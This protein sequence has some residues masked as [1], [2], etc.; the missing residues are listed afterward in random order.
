MKKIFMT[1]LIAAAL[2]ACNNKAKNAEQ[3]EET[4]VQTESATGT[5]SGGVEGS[6]EGAE[7]TIKA[8]GATAAPQ[9]TAKAPVNDPQVTAKMHEE[10][11]AKCK[12]VPTG[13]IEKDAQAMVD[14]QLDLATKSA[15]GKDVK[16]ENMEATGMLLKLGE[17]YS[18]KNQQDE[19]QK[20]LSQKL[21]EGIKKLKMEKLGS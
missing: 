11:K 21:A 4:A 13:D 12:Y 6:A 16:E 2:V 1:V 10:A 19:F 17:Y 9:T 15:E 8:G 20:V 5:E 18:Q 3:A 14:K 7:G